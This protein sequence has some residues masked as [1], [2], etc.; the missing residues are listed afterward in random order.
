VEDWD[1]PLVA[2][3]RA[4]RG[5]LQVQGQGPVFPRPLRTRPAPRSSA[6][7]HAQAWSLG[8]GQCSGLICLREKLSLRSAGMHAPF[9]AASLVVAQ[10]QATLLGY[11][12]GASRFD[13]AASSRY[14]CEQAAERRSTRQP[15]QPGMARVTR[16]RRD[17]VIRG[18][19]LA[20]AGWASF[21]AFFRAPRVCFQA[22]LSSACRPAGSARCS[23][24]ACRRA[25]VLYVSSLPV[26]APVVRRVSAC[27]QCDRMG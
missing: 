26:A 20:T 21:G 27:E 14:R 12:P 16:W 23:S 13:R 24:C 5:R 18:R 11:L 3:L 4:R 25:I 22:L 15:L 6:G 8:H 10:R 1:A 9:D 7:G 2:A 19:H 17:P